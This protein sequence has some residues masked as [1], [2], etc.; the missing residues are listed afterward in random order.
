MLNG[1]S[2]IDLCAQGA[3]LP[4]LRLI[5][6]AAADAVTDGEY[7]RAF[8]EAYNQQ[9]AV[10]FDDA[11]WRRLPVLADSGSWTEDLASSDQGDYYQVNISAT[12]PADSA[13]IRGEI[14]A[15]RQHRY[16]LRLTGRDGLP[17][18]VGSAD[19]P[20]RFDS[21]FQSGAAPGEQRGYRITFSG[22]SL[23]ASPGY[24]PAF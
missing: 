10:D 3:I 20:L 18:I 23:W 1:F 6:Y 4:G 12:M 2:D 24:I 11:G 9:D 15:M 5:E 16:L 7:N 8:S 17:V 14:N 19:M 22:P 21:R 13:S